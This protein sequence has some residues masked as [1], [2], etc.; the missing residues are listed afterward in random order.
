LKNQIGRV[1][2]AE[3]REN[4]FGLFSQRLKDGGWIQNTMPEGQDK[5]FD[6]LLDKLDLQ[7]P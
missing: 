3:K 2:F 1:S 5:I 4:H 7:A 6:E